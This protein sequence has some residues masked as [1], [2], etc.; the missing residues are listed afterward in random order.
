MVGRDWAICLRTTDYSE[1]SQVV[2]LFTRETGKFGAL[3]KGARRAKSAFDGPIEIF[4]CGQIQFYPKFSGGLATLT[5]FLQE[6]RFVRLRRHLYAMDCALFAAELLDSLTQ[7]YDP[8]PSLY[9]VFSTFLDD[10]QETTDTKKSL[11][12]LIVFQLSLL[13]EVG[14]RPILNQCVNCRKPYK[15]SRRGAFFSSQAN[16]LVCPDC[17]PAFVGRIRMAPDVAACF[18]DLQQL[19]HAEEA[20]LRDMEQI[21]IGHF[22]E[23]L[24]RRPKMASHFQK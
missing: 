22:T 12:L 17:E 6:P 10:V 20:T 19:T 8:H 14:S 7:P 3:A 16:G 18:A 5:E 13:A 21:L 11:A 24:H 9:G 4:S 23:M 1:T 2:T 15:Q